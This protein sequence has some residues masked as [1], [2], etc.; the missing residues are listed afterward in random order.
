MGPVST[1]LPLKRADA[2][3]EAGQNPLLPGYLVL[4]VSG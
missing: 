1:L 4:V 3:L 2:K